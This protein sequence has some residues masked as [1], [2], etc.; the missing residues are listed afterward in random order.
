[1]AA[2]TARTSRTRRSAARS[3]CGRA[4]GR[5]PPRTS[6]TSPARRRR[7]SPGSGRWPPATA[8][9]PARSGCS[10]CPRRTPSTA[11]CGSTSSC[12][13][14]ETLQ[15]ITDRLEE[16][17]VIGT[18]AIVEPPV[19]RGVTVVAKLKARP[20]QNPTRLQEERRRGALRVLRPD[21]RRPGRDRLA[22]RA[23]GQRRRGLLGPPGP[24]RDGAG[25]GCPAVRGRPG[26]RPA[27]PADDAPR[28]R[29]A[30]ARV[31]LRAPGPRRGRLI[32]ARTPSVSSARTRSVRRCPRCTRRTTS[33]S[34]P[35]RARRGARAGHQHARQPRRLFRP[36]PDAGR[37]PE[38][39]RDLGGDRDRRRVEHR[40]RAAR[41]SPGP[42]TCTGL[43]GTAS[44]LGQQ[45]EIYTGGTVEIVENG[46]TAWSIDPGG[47]LPGQPEAARRRPGPRPGPE[48]RRCGPGRCPR[49]R[50][51]AG[52]R[53]A[54]GRDR[55]GRWPNVIG[56]GR[57]A[58]V[59]A[60]AALGAS[61][62]R[63]VTFERPHT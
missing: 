17:R 63:H 54:S 53:G 51:E 44:G 52:P 32:D 33:R 62:V 59:P 1:M 40:A 29:A 13:S 61:R 41:R 42:S 21:Q 18:R 30:R 48:G 20:R 57:R 8:P 12:P 56:G 60:V 35:E 23:A 9:M 14:D 37:L 28:A 3:G 31:Q 4:A 16:I 49:R 15:K 46:G 38:L 26:H 27:R 25:R 34:A 43:R 22:V 55:E 58:L 19:Y 2:S 39:A 24:A 36:V 50:R 5:S 11:G 7:K 45:V 10:S 47:E 6:S